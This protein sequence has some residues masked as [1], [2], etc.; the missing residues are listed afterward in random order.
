MAYCA[1]NLLIHS[2][3]LLPELAPATEHDT[4]L[5]AI[6]IRYGAIDRDGLPDGQPIGPFLWVNATS[7]WLHV[8]SVAHFLIREGRTIVIDPAA[9]IDEDSLRVF[10]LASPIGVL[11]FQRGHLVL[12]GNAIRIGD[13]CLVCVGQSGVGKST[14][15]AGFMQR[16]Y[17]AIAD[18]VVPINA[19]CEVVPGAPR[20]KLWKDVLDKLQWDSSALRRI[21]PH[22]ERFNV[23]IVH[24]GP[25]RALPVRWVYTLE[26]R[27]AEVPRI[28]AIYGMNRFTPLANQSYRI[29]FMTELALKTQHLALCGTLAGRIHLAR[30]VR[31]D[32][33]FDLEPLIDALLADIAEHP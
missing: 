28:E 33:A 31:P 3:L 32:D 12:H 11:L 10:L 19:A 9:G 5:P 7:L 22:T 26:R 23:P 18:D 20:L 8:P 14:L 1:Y 4:T 17:E 30:V 16:G 2:D 24:P 27:R 25:R 6:V 13:Q 29:R 21:R 15:A